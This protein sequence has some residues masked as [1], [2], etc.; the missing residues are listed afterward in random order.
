MLKSLNVAQSG[1]SAAKIAVE[2]VSNNIANEN[3]PGYKKRV[4]Q[5]SELELIDGRMTGRGVSA[6]EAYRI[7][8]QYMYDNLMS[9]NSKSNYYDEISSLVG[10]VEAMF[11]ETDS[12]GFSSDLDRY[13]QS[14]ENLRSNPNSEIYRTTYKTQGKVLVDS[15]QNLYSN[16]EKQEELT[17][18]SLEENVK[19]VNNLINEIG[20][21]NEQLGQ[22]RVASNDL[23]DKRDELEKELSNYVDIEVNRTNDEYELKVGGA[24]AVRFSTNIREIELVDDNVTQIDRF[25]FVDNDL[26]NNLYD[27]IKN[28]KDE[29]GNISA[30]TFLPGDV[31]TYKL[32]NQYEVSVTI[33]ESL[34]FDSN[35]VGDETVS[36]DNIIRALAYKINHH[37]GISES[38]KAYNGNYS[39]DSDGNKIDASDLDKFLVLESKVE[40]ES[41]AFEGRISITHAQDP[42]YST[43]TT[44]IGT[45]LV[46]SNPLV[47]STVLNNQ[48][49]II[50]GETFTTLGEDYTLL[51]TQI[52]NS[53]NFSASYDE[54]TSTLLI[55]NT[56]AGSAQISI[57][58][59]SSPTYNDIISTINGTVGYAAS[60]GNQ[61]VING[62]TFVTSGE[63]FTNLASEINSSPSFTASF[64]GGTNELT[65]NGEIF[66]T[67]GASYSDIASLVNDSAS[68]I[69]STE[70]RGEITINFNGAEKVF[71]VTDTMTYDDLVTQIDND[72]DLN[73]ELSSSGNLVITPSDDST[74][75]TITENLPTAIGINKVDLNRDT[76]FKDEYQSQEAENRVYLSVYD[77]E[78]N[79][80]SG[81]LK[82]QTENLTTNAVNNKLVDYKEKLDNFARALSDMYSKYVKTDQDEYLYGHVAS[83]AY[84]G[85]YD[86]K[87]INLFSGGDVKSLKFDEN[88]VNDLVQSDLDYMGTIQWKKDVE[89]DG[90]EQDASSVYAT[91][92]SEFYQEIRVNISSDKENN[93]FLLEAQESVEQSLQSNFDQLTKVDSD[94]EMVNLIKFQAAYTANAKII[95]VVDEMLQTI[96]NIR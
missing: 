64:N 12:S 52:N 32:D 55:E 37:T 13:F 25:S 8:S 36:E 45:D 29:D 61:L 62:E 9:E 75:L 74:L 83:D 73:A 58:T 63:D 50:D 35:L 59:S 44:V 15:L 89:F 96:L 87:S 40:G 21:I 79:I 30:R 28:I 41:G 77:S 84:D 70:N 38:V 43:S 54:L 94:E 57:D 1:L 33:G 6:D 14:V 82:A 95:T 18:Y 20:S 5:L 26:D 48:H 86:I 72:S 56:G 85:A 39:I 65:I 60:A 16:I 2:N 4:V 17:R 81:I 23:L 51:A 3:T 19:K 76:V 88:A 68:F 24:I 7:T 46:D 22:H 10:N 66:S 92:F 80:S 42:V 69:S 34:D 71:T 31:V 91:S 11:Q 93:D 27:G 47:A 49:M 78:V 53:G 67:V 90:F